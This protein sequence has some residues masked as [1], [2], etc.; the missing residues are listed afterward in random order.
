MSR[1]LS[2]FVLAAL[3]GPVAAQASWVAVYSQ[4]F[5]SPRS[6]AFFVHHEGVGR[7]QLLFGFGATGPLNEAWELQGA[8]WSLAAPPTL[9]IRQEPAVAY[10]ALRQVV[11]V[12]GGFSQTSL[13]SLDD[14]WEWDGVT[15]TQR[16]PVN[17]PPARQGAACAFDRVRGRV[18]LFGGFGAGNTKLQDTWEWDGFDWTPRANLPTNPPGRGFARMAY[19]PAAGG[20]L[21]H[22][23]V[24]GNAVTSVPLNDTWTFNG[25]NW[26]QRFPQTPPPFRI[27][28]GLVT[29]IG[30]QRI[31]LHGGSLSDPHTWEWNGA[32]W[33]ILANV[34][35]GARHSV[36][37]V[38]EAPQRRIVEHGGFI[39]P[40][41]VNV[42]VND[43]WSYRTTQHADAAQFGGGCTGTLGV[44][45]LAG[46]PFSLPWLGDLARTRVTN[47]PTGS[48]G[49]IFVASFAT[50]AP[51]PLAAYGAPGCDLLVAP[52]VSAISIATGNSAEW[53]LSIPS[54]PVLAGA[55]FRQ[56][57]FVFDFAANPFGL[58]ATNGITLTTGVR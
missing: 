54:N 14:T 21:L 50:I 49:V 56:Q 45:I 47:V 46:A 7:T 42:V 3:A 36:A 41:G 4:Q 51:I 20:L 11:I 16:S 53:L 22:G 34:G 58:V 15:W 12:F 33:S 18:V 24:G 44:P 13:Q 27:G 52:D 5:P 19:D 32:E 9:P 37:M 6:S 28:A 43:T 57:G 2:L 17:V 40:F 23:G 55:T 39:A 35:P 48:F 38:Y 30:R 10:D 31:V 29:D 25:G 26:A 8:Q 1:I